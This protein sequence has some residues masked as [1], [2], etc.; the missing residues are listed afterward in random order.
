MA[1]KPK[2]QRQDVSDAKALTDSQRVAVN[3]SATAYASLAAEVADLQGKRDIFSAKQAVAKGGSSED[4]A[5]S[6]IAKREMINSQ[7][8]LCDSLNV[9]AK[10]D[11]LLLLGSGFEITP[12]F[13]PSVEL[14]PVEKFTVK[15]TNVPGRV[16]LNAVKGDGCLTLEFEWGQ[17]PTIESVTVWSKCSQ[18]QNEC[19][20]SGL[21]SGGRF[22]GRVNS[23]GRRG[24]QLMSQPINIIVL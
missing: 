10:G 12:E 17:G 11:I 7:N 5:A 15:N 18:S 14:A 23:I 3:M 2:K 24:Q 4:K 21:I 6:K 16:K 20:V 1:R 19:T 9:F 13:Y 22:W 8:S